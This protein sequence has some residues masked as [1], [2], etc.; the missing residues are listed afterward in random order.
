[1]TSHLVNSSNHPE[2]IL[3]H[4]CARG[5]SLYAHMTETGGHITESNLAKIN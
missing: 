3:D 1:M 5:T 4:V 2:N